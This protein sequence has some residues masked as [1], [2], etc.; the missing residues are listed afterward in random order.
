MHYG[1]RHSPRIHVWDMTTDRYLGHTLIPTVPT[2][3]V[4]SKT[5]RYAAITCLLPRESGDGLAQSLCVV[6]FSAEKWWPD[7]K[8]P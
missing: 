5:G 1:P 3:L 7:G 6:D 4:L 8:T 2:R